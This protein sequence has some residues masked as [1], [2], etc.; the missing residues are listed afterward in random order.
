MDM[1][2]NKRIVAPTDDQISHCYELL[3]SATMEASQELKMSGISFV[4]IGIR[5]WASE[6][7]TVDA[8]SASQFFHYMATIHD[9]DSDEEAKAKAHNAML[10]ASKDLFRSA[11]L[12]SADTKGSC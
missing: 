8:K 11:E 2:A 3:Y 4:L 6:M 5:L 7:A 1:H 10:Q 9:P 12:F